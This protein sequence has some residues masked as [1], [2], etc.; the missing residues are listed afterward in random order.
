MGVVDDAVEDGVGDSGL[1]DH[2]VPLSNRQLGGNQSRFAPVALFEDFQEI[3]ALLI[4]HV[5]DLA[6]NVH[7]LV[8]LTHHVEQNRSEM[9]AIGL[10]TEV[11]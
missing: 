6:G 5:R 7:D 10:E 4:D 11:A 8:V 3:E 1:T 9:E 2:V